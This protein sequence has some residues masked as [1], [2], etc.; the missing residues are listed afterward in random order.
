MNYYSSRIKVQ[1]GK[2]MNVTVIDWD[3]NFKG[4]EKL[5]EIANQYLK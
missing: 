3:N 1:I 5:H 2:F 4:Y